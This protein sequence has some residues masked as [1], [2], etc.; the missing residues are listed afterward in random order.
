[1]NGSTSELKNTVKSYGSTLGASLL[2]I[3]SMERFSDC[4]AGFGPSD[5]MPQARAV[6]VMAKP[7]PRELIIND[8]RLTAYSQVHKTV[9]GLLDTIA[10]QMAC[11][12]EE[13]GYRAYPVPADDPY[14]SWDEEN[15]HG[16]GDLSHRHAA[17]AAGL[18]VLGKNTQLIT[19]QYGNRVDL[20][21]VIT[22]MVLEPDPLVGEKLCPDACRLCLDA[23]PVGAL[24]GR[25]VVQKLC[26]KQCVVNLPRGFSV[27]GCWEC[28]RVCP[29]GMKTPPN[30]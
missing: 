30:I 6:V 1:M 24:D 25:S 20:V 9:L 12:I 16:N 23:C 10:Y 7:I 18:G 21:S 11:F 2:G 28:R 22:D 26:R 19:P 27:Y 3:A 5:I 4:P 13:K 15:Q 14:T 8:Y 29:V 17:V